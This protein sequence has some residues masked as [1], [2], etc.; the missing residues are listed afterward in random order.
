MCLTTKELN[1]LLNQLMQG[2]MSV[3]P[4]HYLELIS[5]IDNMELCGGES[6]DANYNTNWP[7]RRKK[8]VKLIRAFETKKNMIC[9]ECGCCFSECTCSEDELIDSLLSEEPE[10]YNTLAHTIYK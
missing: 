1:T 5:E 10:Y 4:N 3:T 7:D 2:V 6:I 8:L 9:T